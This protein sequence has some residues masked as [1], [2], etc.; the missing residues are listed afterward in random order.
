MKKT[1]FVINKKKIP[2]IYGGSVESVGSTLSATFDG[3]F[4]YNPNT[5][6]STD[7]L[8]MQ[9]ALGEGPVYRINPNGPQDIEIDNKYIDD[10]IDFNTNN[11][12]SDIFVANYRT[13]TETQSPMSSFF[14][15]IVNSVRFSS[16]LQLKS[17]LSSSIS[18]PAPKKSSIEFFPTSLSEDLEPI[19]SIRFKFLIRNLRFEQSFGVEP[20]SLSLVALI[21]GRDEVVNINNYIAGNGTIINS[22]VEG[23]MAAE[24]EIKIPDNLKTSI[25]YRVSM[26]KLSEDI[27]EEGFISEVEAIGFDEIRKEHYSY[28]S[29]ALAGYAVKSTDFRTESLPTFTSLLKGLIVDVPSNYNQPVLESGEVDWRQIELPESDF[30]SPSVNGYFTQKNPSE[31][32]FDPNINIYE[33]V[34]DGTY[35]KDW[36]ENRVWIIRHILVNIL[37]VPE[38]SIDKYN[39]YNVAQYVDAVDPYTGNFIGVDGFSDGSF[40]YKPRNYS[41]EVS[42]T[43]LGIPEGISVKERRFVCGISITDQTNA[44][45]LITA[46]ASGMRAIVHTNGNKIRIIID[47]PDILPVAIFNETNIQE[48]SFKISGAREEDIPTGVEVS[49]IDLVDHFTKTSVV[50]DS[51]EVLEEDRNNR[52]GID[53]IGCTRKS[54][55]LRLAKYHLDIN[56]SSKRRVSFNTTYE[57][58]DLEIGD[59]ISVSNK[60]AGLSYGF[61]GQIFSNSSVGSSSV[62]LEYYGNPPITETLFT[63]NTNP[64]VL[65]LFSQYNNKL[66]YY[67]IDNSA[68]SYQLI[69]SGNTAVGADLVEV[70]ILEKLDSSLKVFS[71]NTAFSESTAPRKYDLWALGE[72]NPSNI[73]DDTSGK[74]FKIESLSFATDLVSISATEYIPSIIENIDQS[75]KYFEGRLTS[76][77]NYVTP[78]V[79]LLNLKSIPSKTNEGIVSYNLLISTTT[80]STNYSVPITT[81]V[82][83]AVVPNIIEIESQEKV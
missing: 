1:Y 52:I 10:L 41:T 36:T 49:Y 35:K 42:N 31:V 60:T 82:R 12:K 72:I 55:A 3:S 74:L 80:D 66:E 67:I 56:R 51:S 38:S 25:G 18:V 58:S 76:N 17:G 16:P 22:I 64:I 83:Y 24:I 28:P 6:K 81:Y 27:G 44:W 19:D 13:G 37:G 75:P 23:S 45:D 46:L 65:K 9:L 39:F 32:S 54:E 40:R 29:T 47:R 43:L 14:T 8:Y 63:S 11:T 77:Q 59:I 4:S 7:I 26:F 30:F 21:H 53:A 79:P 50:L 5:S 15:E 20:A 34:W 57:A 68:N 48:K 78:P 69:T 71:S 61:G 62:L 73:D 70:S 2:L 33:G